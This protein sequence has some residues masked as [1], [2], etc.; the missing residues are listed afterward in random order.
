MPAHRVQYDLGRADPG[1]DPGDTNSF[2][3]RDRSNIYFPM[4][5]AGTETRTLPRAT[6]AGVICTLACQTAS[7]QITVTVKSISKVPYAGSKFDCVLSV[8]MPKA[9]PAVMP[10]MTC[11]IEFGVEGG[12]SE[13]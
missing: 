3:P 13:E 6:R 4:V 11:S 10:G 5:S 12:E 1:V 7:T 8:K 2:D 9:E